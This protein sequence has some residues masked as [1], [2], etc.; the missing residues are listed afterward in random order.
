[1]ATLILLSALT[2]SWT[3]T[4][5]A[6]NPSAAP[7]TGVRY[8]TG[9]EI[10][11]IAD[12]IVITDWLFCGPFAVGVREGITEAIDDVATLNPQ[13]GD[14]L[15]SAL[16]PGG[17]VRW[18][19]LKSDSLGWLETDYDSIPW[20]S[21]IDYYGIAGAMATGYALAEFYSP[22]KARA[23]A[24]A[25]RLGGFFLNGKGYLGDIYG[26]GWFKAPV[27]I[28][29]GINRVVLRVSGYGDQRVRFLLIPNEKPFLVIT[30]DITAPDLIAVL[31]TL[32]AGGEAT[33]TFNTWLGIPLLNTTADRLDSI[34]IKISLDT[35]LLAD[36]TVSNVPPL[37]VKK[38]AVA[39]KLPALPYDTSPIPVTITS[40]WRNWTNI[41]TFQLRS[42]LPAQA[43]KKTFI[44]EMDSSCQYYA[45]LYPENYDPNERYS[46]ILSLHGAGV[47]A[48][49]L[50]EC[51][52]PKNWA[53]VVCPTNRR[54]Y[55]FDWQDWGRL[56]VLEVLN[57]CLKELPV[58][59]DLVVLTGHSMGGHGTWHIGLTHP[60]RFAGIA[61]AAGWP[62]LNLYVPTFLQKSN[63][64]APPAK[65]AIRDMALRPD[66]APALL[67]NALNLPVFILHG[68]E[69]D[70]VPTLHG[71]NFALWLSA[72][73][74]RYHY[75]EVPGKKHWWNYDDGTVC[76]DDP[77]LMNFLKNCR[78]H[79]GPRHI[80][81]RT[82]D[83]GQSS[84]A[85]WLKIDRVAKVG[86]DAFVE[87]WADDS[88]VK[89]ITDNIT[90]LTLEF[91]QRLFFPGNIQLEIDNRT[92]IKNLSVPR[93]ITVHRT[94]QD[95]RPGRV[96][97]APVRK[98]GNLYGPAKQVLMRPFAIVYGTN[99]PEITEHLRHAAVQEAMRWWLIGNGTT[100]VLPD[101][102][103]VPLNRNLI[104]LG[105]EGENKFTARIARSLPV[106]IKSGLL[107]FPAP[108]FKDESLAVILTYPNPLNP[109]HLL[110]LR[111]GTDPNTT[112]FSLFYNIIGSGT[113]IPDFMV[114]DRRVR[115]YGWTGVRAAGFFNPDWR[116][117]PA[118]TVIS[119]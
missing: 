2:L 62:F 81:F 48:S 74:Y 103:P 68:G 10:P 25:T 13:P 66:N 69:D 102:A 30:A 23:L 37:G 9:D 76:V 67:E 61:P 6:Q 60:D 93:T 58:D 3:T 107:Y 72:L 32:A 11:S 47:E 7:V 27:I 34:R 41:D 90:Q 98:T 14:S 87:A 114:V 26:N 5:V 91:D 35:F 21:I 99:N 29:S 101:T 43:H 106:K 12:T 105:N 78:R 100:E 20:D 51:F 80:R 70:N 113:G 89:I 53:F 33:S 46:L 52:K 18:H 77:D 64:F 109:E 16:A 79:P 96:K 22:V 116:F 17:V 82:A 75:K 108:A 73:N 8:E 49:G 104:V 55:G 110:L 28:D 59:P 31:P 54:P 63:I 118:T 97:A 36:T 24:V 1:M 117:D 95:W 88:T 19:W 86:Q 50:A 40:Q 94:G 92:V 85:Y 15:R 42:R 4:I 56:D 45:I 39:V 57:L 115:R 111:M 71:R 112:R 119:R 65:L 38:P 84:S 44:S 83:I